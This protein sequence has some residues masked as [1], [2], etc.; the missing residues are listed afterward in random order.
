MIW[1]IYLLLLFMI[2]VIIYFV[3]VNL[4]LIN[5]FRLFLFL[6]LAFLNWNPYSTT[7]QNQSFFW[8]ASPSPLVLKRRERHLPAHYGNLK[9]TLSWVEFDVYLT[10]SSLIFLSYL[11]ETE[12]EIWFVFSFITSYPWQRLLK[13]NLPRNHS[14]KFLMLWKYFF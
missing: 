11:S 5:I 9:K 8:Q 12:T 7:V 1:K 6:I 10:S 14:Q 3:I 2:T 13:S 4:W